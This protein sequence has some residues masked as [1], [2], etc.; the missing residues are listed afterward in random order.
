VQL[1]T[2][3]E[4]CDIYDCFV[5]F[6][7]FSSTLLCNCMNVQHVN[8]DKRPHRR[9]D[10]S[11]GIEWIRFRLY[12]HGFLGLHEYTPQT[13]SRSFQPFSQ[14][15]RVTSDQ[16]TQRPRYSAPTDSDL[17]V[18]CGLRSRQFFWFALERVAEKITNMQRHSRTVANYM[19]S[20]HL[21]ASLQ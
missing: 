7:Y 15:S 16:Q 13:A 14:G 8:F 21:I 2:A 5:L 6:L 1:H 11:R 3:G 17:Q 10:H 12:I 9:L 19:P 20:R 4:V 18:Q